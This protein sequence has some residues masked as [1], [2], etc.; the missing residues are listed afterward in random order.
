MG[1]QNN[2]RHTRKKIFRECGSL[3]TRTT[4]LTLL[5]YRQWRRNDAKFDEHPEGV[6]QSILPLEGHSPFLG[7]K[8][9]GT[10]KHLSAAIDAVTS[11]G[12]NRRTHSLQECPQR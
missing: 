1:T 4:T 12:S 10:S 2:F 8:G 7:I 6:W 11:P 9:R 3:T 5:T